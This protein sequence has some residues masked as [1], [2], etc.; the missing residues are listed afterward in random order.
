MSAPVSEGEAIR[1]GSE[2][3]LPRL[4]VHIMDDVTLALG[5]VLLLG[6]IGFL[7]ALREIR[8][9]EARRRSKE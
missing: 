8:R 5:S 9:D 7:I 4:I 3:R 6:V 1:R 2:V